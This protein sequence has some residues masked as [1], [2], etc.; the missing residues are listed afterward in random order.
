MSRNLER[1]RARRAWAALVWER[2]HNVG[3]GG[4]ARNRDGGGKKS[5]GTNAVIVRPGAKTRKQLGG[6]PRGGSGATNKR[7][8]PSKPYVWPRHSS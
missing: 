6:E 2:T 8:V 4:S 3:S 7:R 5:R 1:E